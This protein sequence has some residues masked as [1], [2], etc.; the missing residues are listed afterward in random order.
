M[1]KITAVIAEMHD[2]E[3]SRKLKFIDHSCMLSGRPHLTAVLNN[4]YCNDSF[5]H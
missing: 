5:S 1:V 2:L 3:Y 4:N